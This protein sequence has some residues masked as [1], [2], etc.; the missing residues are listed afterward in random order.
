MSKKIK[1]V[2][3]ISWTVTLVMTK[4]VLLNVV[5][6]AQHLQIAAEDVPFVTVAPLKLRQVGRKQTATCATLISEFTLR[7][8]PESFYGFCVNVRVYWINELFES[9][10]WHHEHTP[11]R[12]AEQHFDILA[13]RPWRLLSQATHD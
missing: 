6:G 7:L 4:T 10:Q 3:V 12:S 13:R 8:H 1:I 2:N 5:I 9:A 11:R